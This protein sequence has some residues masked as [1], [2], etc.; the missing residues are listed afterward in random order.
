MG[1][2]SS[3]KATCVVI[4]VD[5]EVSSVGKLEKDEEIDDDDEEKEENGVSVMSSVSFVSVV[6]IISAIPEV[7]LESSEMDGDKGAAI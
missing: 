2:N 6:F 4:G 1:T 7:V 5:D 3:V